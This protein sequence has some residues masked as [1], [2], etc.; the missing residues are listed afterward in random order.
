MTDIA[1]RPKC[2]CGVYMDLRSGRGYDNAMQAEQGVWY[3]HPQIDAFS[4][5]GHFSSTL[6]P[7][8][9]PDTR[10]PQVQQ[11]AGGETS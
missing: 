7:S 5:I 9:S 3:D 11:T 8:R 10:G 1:E 4:M 2:R 6:L